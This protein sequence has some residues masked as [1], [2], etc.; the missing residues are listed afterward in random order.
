MSHPS[1][2]QRLR[3]HTRVSLRNTGIRYLLDAT[4][5]PREHSQVSLQ[6]PP[7]GGVSPLHP[8]RSSAKELTPRKPASRRT[9]R[10]PH[11][12]RIATLNGL[13][14]GPGIGTGKRG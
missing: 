11:R 2:H 14:I 9:N 8:V 13:A 6:F 5:V 1:P 12:A 10:R 4:M 7:R 3:R